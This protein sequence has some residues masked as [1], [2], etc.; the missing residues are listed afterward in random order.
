MLTGPKP[1]GIV[2]TTVL[3]VVSMTDKLFEMLLATYT[4][5]PSGRMAILTGP[6]PTAIVVATTLVDSSI[7]DIVFERALAT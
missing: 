2:A 1:T 4:R 6:A 5:V 3:L 7:T